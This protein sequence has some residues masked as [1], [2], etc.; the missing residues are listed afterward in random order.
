MSH[1]HKVAIERIIK[2]CEKSKTFTARIQ[3]ILD[4]A[5]YS[6]GMTANQRRERLEEVMYPAL[7]AN[8]DRIIERM[9]Q[10]EENEKAKMVVGTKLNSDRNEI[11][12]KAG[13]SWPDF[14]RMP[15]ETQVE[16]LV[17]ITFDSST[18]TCVVSGTRSKMSK[19]YDSKTKMLNGFEKLTKLEK[20]EIDVLRDLGFE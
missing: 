1:E 3:S 9:K 12:K 6:I 4:I 8:R 2:L 19:T 14:Y 13:D 20:V 15:I 5:Y 11:F 10:E 16:R 17:K 7:Q 18:N